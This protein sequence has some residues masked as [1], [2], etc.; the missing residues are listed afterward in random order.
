LRPIDTRRDPA[1][2]VEPDRGQCRGNGQCHKADGGDSRSGPGC[3]VC[4]TDRRLSCLHGYSSPGPERRKEL[5]LARLSGA[6]DDVGAAGSDVGSISGSEPTLCPELALLLRHARCLGLR[7]SVMS[8]GMPLERRRLDDL[9]GRVDVLAIGLH[10]VPV[11]HDRM[12]GRLGKFATMVSRLEGVG[13]G[14]HGLPEVA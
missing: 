1:G 6:L 7:S 9:R 3:G 12:H 4:S 5:P 10:G 14:G 2:V 8:N 11:A 13:G